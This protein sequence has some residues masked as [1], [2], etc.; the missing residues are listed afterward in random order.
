M[1]AAADGKP[2]TE[3]CQQ[4]GTW[5]SVPTSNK[6]STVCPQVSRLTPLC[7]NCSTCKL[8]NHLCHPSSSQGCFDS[9]ITGHLFDLFKNQPMPLDLWIHI[10][11]CSSV[12]KLHP[13]AIFPYWK[14]QRAASWKMPDPNDI[15]KASEILRWKTLYKNK[16]LLLPR[17]RKMHAFSVSIQE[18][19]IVVLSGPL[20]YFPC[21]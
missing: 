20:W 3:P 2:G 10:P 5:A 7:H 9:V 18:P 11:K 17:Q 21:I 6:D 4:S 8:S 19:N 14:G 1:K 16:M 13:T 12:I 15:L